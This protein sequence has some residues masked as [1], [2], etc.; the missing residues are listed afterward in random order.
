MIDFPLVVIGASSGGVSALMKLCAQLPGDFPAAVLVVQ[1]TSPAYPSMLPRIL[2][3]AGSLHAIHPRDGQSLHPGLIY[4]APPDHHLLVKKQT[5]AL[6]RGPK[7]NRSRPA[8]DP[9]F[10]SAALSAG[11]RTI[12]VV[13]TGNLDDGTSGLHAIKQA[14][15]LTV[16]Q[17]PDDAEYGSMPRSALGAVNVDHR[18][19]LDEMGALLTT[20]VQNLLRNPGQSSMSPEEQRRLEIEVSI[21]GERHALSQGVTHLGPPSLVTCPDCGGTLMELKEG[22]VTRFRCHTGHAYTANSLLSHVSGSIEEKAYTVLRT[23]EEAVILLGM[24]SEQRQHQGDA[25]GAE[26]LRASAREVEASTQSIR[27]LARDSRI[28]SGE[29]VERPTSE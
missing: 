14:G 12:G 9:L 4:V 26:A 23:L 15:G 5:V 16:V 18:V 13:L 19:P 24:L 8:I 2:S 22:T 20:L 7:E 29:E 21:A 10:R 17:D 1:H 3:S 25:Q 6:T 27:R 11:T 28:L